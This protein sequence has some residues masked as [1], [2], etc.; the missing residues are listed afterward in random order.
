M[1]MTLFFFCG[2]NS[3]LLTS[4]LQPDSAV[5]PESWPDGPM[6]LLLWRVGCSGQ[7]GHSAGHAG[8]AQA[9]DAVRSEGIGQGSQ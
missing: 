2:I 7:P 1:T 8:L 9:W 6:G 4:G 3:R 5:F